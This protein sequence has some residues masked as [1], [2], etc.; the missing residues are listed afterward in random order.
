MTTAINLAAGLVEEGA[1]VLV[2]DLDPQSSATAGLGFDI[3][4]LKRPIYNTLLEDMPARELITATGSKGGG[5]PRSAAHD[6]GLANEALPTGD[7]E[8]RGDLPREDVQKPHTNKHPSR[9]ST[10]VRSANLLLRSEEQGAED[11]RK[12]TKE[13]RIR[14]GA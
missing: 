10:R 6:G 7:Q 4:G 1:S 8:S 12:L 3:Y 9:R 13:V 2:V 5:S 11:Y 14:V